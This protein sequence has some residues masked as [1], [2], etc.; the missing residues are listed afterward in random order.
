MAW[1]CR[2]CNDRC[3]SLCR[4]VG[5]QVGRCQCTGPALARE[6]RPGV[7][8]SPGGRNCE[9]FAEL[10]SALRRR[11]GSLFTANPAYAGNPGGFDRG[12]AVGLAPALQWE[13][14]ADTAAST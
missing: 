5:F 12:V 13:I 10:R 2:G 14:A 11:S 7:F 8:I 9:A 3:A 1:I 6:T 4:A